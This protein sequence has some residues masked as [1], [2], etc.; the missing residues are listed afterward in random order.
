MGDKIE[1]EWERCKKTPEP[2]SA[3]NSS[4]LASSVVFPWTTAPSIDAPRS[5]FITERECRH[6]KGNSIKQ[7]IFFL[8]YSYEYIHMRSTREKTILTIRTSFSIFAENFTVE[9]NTATKLDRTVVWSHIWDK[10]REGIGLEYLRLKDSYAEGTIVTF[11]ENGI[12]YE[13]AYHLEW[14]HQWHLNRARCKTTHEQSVH[15]LILETDGKGRWTDG[16]RRNLS[17]LNGCIDLDIWPSSF[18]NTFPIRRLDF[19]QQKRW[20]IPVVFIKAPML[21]VTVVR[22]AYTRLKESLYLYENVSSRFRAE[23]PVDEDGVVMD[24]PGVFQ[25]VY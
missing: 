16:Q 12:P 2:V 23:L 10:K 19:A 1:E 25:R 13:L 11:D 8:L 9:A 20:E 4:G 14:N 17:E 5:C 7:S 3:A 6:F 15:E 24:Y 18:T 21:S 22:Q